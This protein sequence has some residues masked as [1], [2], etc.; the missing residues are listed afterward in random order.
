MASFIFDIDGTLTKPR[1]KMTEDLRLEF[2]KLMTDKKYYL[3]TGSDI[4]KVYDQLPRDIIDKS[5]GLF[6]CLGN[7]F[8]EPLN[9]NALKRTY[10][11]EH[12]WDSNLLMD[13]EKFVRNR[14]YPHKFG[15]HIEKRPGMMNVSCVG[16]GANLE[17][18]EAYFL[19]DKEEKQREL[20]VKFINETFE[21]YEASIGGVI[22]VDICPKGK[23]KSQILDHI[24]GDVIFFGDKI[25]YGNDKP[26]SDRIKE[27]S[28]GTSIEVETPDDLL[29]QIK[30]AQG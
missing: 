13:C 12:K 25:S 22:S 4:Q 19:W 28:R 27:D 6:A 21:N 8:Y 16:R 30:R 24:E 9:E 5:S 2:S 7:V 20:F 29:E 10:I 14:S 15:R 26:L 1:Q 18:R 23:N 3:A 11:I 17:E